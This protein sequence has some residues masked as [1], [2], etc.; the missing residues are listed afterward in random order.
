MKGWGLPEIL[1]ILAG[2]L[3][4]GAFRCL[5]AKRGK[6][7]TTQE[8]SRPPQDRATIIIRAAMACVGLLL[9]MGL[10]QVLYPAFMGWW[11]G[12]GFGFYWR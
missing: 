7:G 6:A 4:V 9:W 11:T 1:A 5:W 10:W 2:M 8:K 3:V 12:K